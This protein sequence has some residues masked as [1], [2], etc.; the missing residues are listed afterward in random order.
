[1]VWNL[2]LYNTFGEIVYHIKKLVYNYCMCII[3]QD[4]FWRFNVKISFCAFEL[5]IYI[6]YICLNIYL[7][8]LL[9]LIHVSTILYD[10]SAH[11]LFLMFLPWYWLCFGCQF[12]GKPHFH[13]QGLPHSLPTVT[14]SSDHSYV[15]RWQNSDKKVWTHT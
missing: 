13:F 9:L 7:C 12:N 2:L 5:I 6:V 10:Y 14:K 11:E 8:V 15:I 3:Y 4:L 1:M